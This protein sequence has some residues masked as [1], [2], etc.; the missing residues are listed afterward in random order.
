M[1]VCTLN[2]LQTFWWG[3]LWMAVQTGG[4]EA[5]YV[6]VPFPTPPAGGAEP[7]LPLLLLLVAGQ[8]L[9]VAQTEVL[10]GGRVI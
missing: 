4:F 6:W 8:Q 9:S 1:R 10:H 7:A 3:S 2:E 5:G